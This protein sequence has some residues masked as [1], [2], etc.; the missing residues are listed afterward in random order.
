MPLPIPSLDPIAEEFLADPFAHHDELRNARPLVWLSSIGCYAMA[1]YAEIKSAMDDWRSFI[2]GRWVGLLDF[3]QEEPWRSPSL[4]LK[5][6]PPLYGRTRSLMNN[7]ASPKRVSGWKDQ[8][9]TCARE[10]AR[11]LAM[12]GRFDAIT[13]LAEPF[14]MRIFLTLVGLRPGGEKAPDPLW[15]DQFQCLRPTQRAARAQ[16]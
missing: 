11:E 12:K 9:L 8:W 6:D 2:S 16:F 15:H 14:A 13:D 5:T 3:A 4:L 7:V 10:L 1:R